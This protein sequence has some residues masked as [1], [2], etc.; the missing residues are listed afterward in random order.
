[1]DALIQNVTKFFPEQNDL[2]VKLWYFH[3]VRAIWILN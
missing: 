2:S 3:V 1:M